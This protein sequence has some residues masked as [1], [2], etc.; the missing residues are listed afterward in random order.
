M[1]V[2]ALLLT[3]GL[4]SCSDT[5]G[6]PEAPPTASSVQQALSWIPTQ[7]TEFQFVDMAAARK[8]WRMSQING[9]TPLE[10]TAWRDYSKKL[11]AASLPWA[12]CA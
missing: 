3:A 8:R 5:A 12:Y 10:G 1:A 2:V 9:T 7:V 4:C 11:Q 6:T